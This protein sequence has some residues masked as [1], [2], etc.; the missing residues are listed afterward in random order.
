ME[1]TMTFRYALAVDPGG[2][3]GWAYTMLGGHWAPNSVI[4]GQMPADDFLDWFA[5]EPQFLDSSCLVLIETFTITA[6]TARLSQQPEPMYVIGVMKFLL[7]RARSCP[8]MQTPAAAKRFCSDSQLKKIG[9]W[10]PGK[11][12]ARDAIRHLVLGIVTHSTGQ[13]REELIQSL[14]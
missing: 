6:Q 4:A 7:R 11:D 5:G 14:V 2:T 13:A 12:H 1:S 3:T 9:L 8:A 10:Q